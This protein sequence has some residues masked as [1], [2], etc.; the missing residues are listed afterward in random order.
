MII[1]LLLVIILL[2]FKP[3]RSLM[4]FGVCALVLMGLFG[5]YFPDLVPHQ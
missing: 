1:I 4:G 2:M 5:A 3:I